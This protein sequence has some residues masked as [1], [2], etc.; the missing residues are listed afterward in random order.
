MNE[1]SVSWPDI[2]IIAVIVLSVIIGIFRGLIQESISLVT[3]VGAIIV[4]VV[5]T[6]EF[7]PYMTF[8]DVPFIRSLSAFMILF[9]LTVFLG[10]IVNFFIGK[11]VRKTPFSVP[12]RVLGSVFGFARGAI[13]V[14]I[15]VLLTGLTQF[16]QTKTWQESKLIQE[17]EKVAIWMKDRLPEK[18]AQPFNF[19]DEPE[20]DSEEQDSTSES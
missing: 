17:F 1:V 16:T 6:Q 5:F 19:D 3:W 7:S 18:Y 2:I 8:T 13:L 9:V 20:N 11:L 15:A 4:G 12:D 10:A 14:T